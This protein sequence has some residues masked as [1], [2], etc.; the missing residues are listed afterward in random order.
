M[1]SFTTTAPPGN[2]GGG[3]APARATLVSLFEK[4]GLRRKVLRFL[5]AALA[6]VALGGVPVWG[7][8]EEPPC[9]SADDC[10]N[11]RLLILRDPAGS[12]P[13]S[14][15]TCSGAD[16]FSRT[17]YRVY[18]RYA[19]DESTPDS[20][21][22]FALAH[23]SL[24]AR[25]A[26]DNYNGES[27]IDLAATRSCF[28]AGPGSA[29]DL[30]G[31]VVFDGLVPDEIALDFL[32]PDSLPDCGA[33]N[34][35]ILFSPT[36]PANAEACPSGKKCVY[37][38]LF[39]V[40]VRTVAGDTI[41][42]KCANL[43]YAPPPGVSLTPCSPAQCAVNTN[44]SGQNGIF[45]Y[46]VPLAPAPTGDN[47]DLLVRLTDPWLSPD[48][49]NAE[50]VAVEILNSGTSSVTVNYLEFMV[51]VT[52]GVAIPDP[53]FAAPFG[54]PLSVKKVVTGTSTLEYHVKYALAFSSGL[55][56]APNTP[57]S[58]DTLTIGPPMPFNQYWEGEVV[59][60]DESKS[61]VRSAGE[62][63]R[64]ELSGTVVELQ[65]TGGTQPCDSTF[66]PKEV[67]FT[68]RAQEDTTG[69]CL[70]PKLL[71]GFYAEGNPGNI[72]LVFETFGCH[73]GLDLGGSL[74]IAGVNFINGWTCNGIC[75]DDCLAIGIQNNTELT[76]TLCEKSNLS[77]NAGN[78]YEAFLE[79]EFEG[80]GCINSASLLGLYYHKD[81][82]AELPCVPPIDNSYEGIP[83]CGGQASGRVA[84]WSGDQPMEDVKVYLDA[85]SGCSSCPR[86]SIFTNIDGE[87]VLCPCLMCDTFVVTPYKNSGPLNGVS[88]FDLVLINKHV[89]GT[90]Q[91]DSPYKTIAADVNK[92]NSVTTFDIVELRKLILGIYTAFP[93]NTSWRF[94]RKDHT[95]SGPLNPFPFPET[96][97]VPPN[98]N[99]FVAIKVGDVNGNALPRPESERPPLTIAWHLPEEAKPGK[100][101]T[102]P[103]VYTGGEPLQ[104]FQIG[105]RFDPSVLALVGPSK[106]E[107]PAVSQESFGLARAAQGEIRMLWLPDGAEPDQYALPGTTLFHL[108]F[109]VLAPL[110][111]GGL[112]LS[113][114][115]DVLHGLAW[116]PDDA[117]YDLRG[118]NATEAARPVVGVSAPAHAQQEALR[119]ICRPNPTASGTVLAVH[120]PWDGQGRVALFDAFGKLVFMRK[121]EFVAGDQDV[122]MPEAADVPPGVYIWKVFASGQKAVGHLVKH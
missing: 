61:R 85:A 16:P 12:C 13:G 45:P 35:R 4:M 37:A 14:S 1:I 81:P 34:A 122:H 77:L 88:T 69:A 47:A 95:F 83:A 99:D 43:D 119:A 58:L 26:L 40:V 9:F 6:V 49:D 41:L 74:A 67:R 8:T 64:L 33:T 102:V 80:V 31:K 38:Y 113:V 60:T 76:I 57:V 75:P 22:T 116:S 71:I 17:V 59:L 65:S 94:V 118:Q 92:S 100:T 18:L 25:V 39:P 78:G 66:F 28:L 90:E 44:S 21:L 106:G 62:C 5:L 97:L 96:A 63:S 68:I 82:N 104:A 93:N 29:W 36:V 2:P 91:F 110:P 114:D 52:V 103:V 73:V 115:E 11:L 7:Q 24:N 89:L 48:V 120:A 3:Q 50:A 20:L 53:L 98:V 51:K 54:P 112:P 27:H 30:N 56:L 107:L 105:L 32:N 109:D 108:T 72:E 86:D 111:D 79:V 84:F 19:V 15:G 117:Q 42:L 87:Y 101:I 10:S 23:Q 55:T 46:V 121:V 70:P